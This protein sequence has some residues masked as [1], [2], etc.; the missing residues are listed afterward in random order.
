VIDDLAQECVVPIALLF[1]PAALG[2]VL[3]GGDPPAVLERCADRRKPAAVRAAYQA[4]INPALRD[5]VDDRGAEFVDVAIEKSLLL[6]MPHQ[7][8]KMASRLHDVRREPEHV[9]VATVDG[10][11]AAGGVVLHQP[12]HHVVQR[13]IEALPLH[14]QPLLRLAVLPVDLADDQEQH[15]CDHEGGERRGDDQEFGLRMPVGKCR[16]NRVGCDHDRR[17]MTEPRRRAQPLHSI[18]RAF[19]ALGMLA[20]LCQHR[21][22][23][24]GGGEILPNHLID[25]RVAREQGPIGVKQRDGRARAWSDG[26][27]ELLIV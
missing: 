20:S 14:L 7:V 13:R 27:K 2:D 6:A 9:E 23:E 15:A 22:H 19:D 10:D 21:S 5:I 17:E 26:S 18:D 16:G 25:A 3:D 11:D 8:T 4:A 24:R 1:Q 12:L